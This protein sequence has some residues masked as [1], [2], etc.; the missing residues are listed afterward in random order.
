[1]KVLQRQ[2]LVAV[3]TKVTPLLMHPTRLDYHGSLLR[4]RLAYVIELAMCCQTL[5]LALSHL[6]SKNP[7]GPSSCMMWA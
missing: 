3:V 1:M 5:A 4:T 7:N 6:R 2:L